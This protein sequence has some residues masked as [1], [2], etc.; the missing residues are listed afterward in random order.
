[1]STYDYSRIDHGEAL[2]QLQ[3]LIGTLMSVVADQEVRIHQLENAAARNGERGAV[4]R[5]SDADARR[6]DSLRLGDGAG[7]YDIISEG[8]VNR[9]QHH[10]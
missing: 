6:P 2:G 9:E 10:G 7:R 3:D 8:Q 5:L 1:M 4:A